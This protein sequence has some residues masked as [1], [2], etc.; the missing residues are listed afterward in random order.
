MSYLDAI[1]GKLGHRE[2]LTES[3]FSPFMDADDLIDPSKF[4][5]HLVRNEHITSLAGCDLGE[6]FKNFLRF[7][8]NYNVTMNEELE[9]RIISRPADTQTFKPGEIVLLAE[10]KAA[11]QCQVVIRKAIL[12]T[13]TVVEV[14]NL[15]FTI[16]SLKQ[17]E[18]STHFRIRMLPEDNFLKDD[19]EDTHIRDNEDDE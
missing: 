13:Q 4:A 5:S 10:K 17:A 12:K 11:D 2:C 18:Y 3:Y 1:R 8:W 14:T 16:Q 9:K 7:P 19:E 15:V 6:I